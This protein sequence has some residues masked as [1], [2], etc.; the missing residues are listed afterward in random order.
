MEEGVK[1]QRRPHNLEFN[2][3]KWVPKVG[4]SLAHASIGVVSR[5]QNRERLVLVA[6]TY[7][8]IVVR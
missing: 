1:V 2:S 6:R 8:S 5:K 7:Y 3:Q 4:F